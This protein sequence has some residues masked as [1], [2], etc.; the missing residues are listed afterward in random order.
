MNLR[1]VLSIIL[2]EPIA[3]PFFLSLVYCEQPESYE[4]TTQRAKPDLR[5][6]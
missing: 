6:V 1:F 4:I 5:V 2:F 3:A